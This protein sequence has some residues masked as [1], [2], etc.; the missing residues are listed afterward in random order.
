MSNT[1]LLI[2]FCIAVGLAQIMARMELDWSGQ[3]SPEKTISLAFAVIITVIVLCAN[4]LLLTLPINAFYVNY[5]AIAVFDIFCF[6]L[7]VILVA[8][9]RKHIRHRYSIPKTTKCLRDQKI[10]VVLCVVHFAR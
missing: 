7:Y 5:T 6:G 8:R 3:Y 4:A 9:V 1:F 10:F 2:S